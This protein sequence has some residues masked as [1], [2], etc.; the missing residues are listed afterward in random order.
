MILGL[1]YNILQITIYNPEW[2]R[3][4]EEEKQQLQSV[5]GNDIL[6]IQHIGSTAIPDVLTIPILDI[7]IGVQNFEAASLLIQP[8]TQMGYAYRGEQ[9]VPKRHFFIKGNTETHHLHI[10]EIEST[11][12][13]NYLLFRDY[14]QKNPDIAGHYSKL[15]IILI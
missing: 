1:P 12:W 8:L 15:K 6:D 2:E 11:N 10:L 13:K 4:F 7:G 3:L 14:L 9:G 5:I